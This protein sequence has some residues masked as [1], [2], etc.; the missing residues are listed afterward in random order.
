[1]K[2]VYEVT[3]QKVQPLDLVIHRQQTLTSTNDWAKAEAAQIEDTRVHLYLTEHQTAGRGRGSN[4]WIDLETG[5]ALL[6]T[7]SFQYAAQPVISQAMGLAVFKASIATWPHLPFGLKAPNDLYCGEKKVAGLLLESVQQGS[8]NRFLVGLGYNVLAKPSTLAD[9]GCLSDF[10]DASE[11]TETIWQGFLER[12]YLE[13]K[14]AMRETSATLSPL[15]RKSLVFA[16][17]QFRKKTTEIADLE[18]DGSI[19]LNSGK[20]IP[21]QT[22]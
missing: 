7:W 4:H 10:L 16:L 9:A 22:I 1:M 2:S 14:Y 11:L 17:N 19:I 6:S 3:Y 18:S 8:K 5:G 20:K 21:W 13:F 12:L 15:Q